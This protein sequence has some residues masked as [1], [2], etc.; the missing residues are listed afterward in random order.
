MYMLSFCSSCHLSPLLRNQIKNASTTS[1][2][3]QFKSI[4]LERVGAGAG[5][6]GWTPRRGWRRRLER[7]SDM[8]LYRKWWRSIPSKSRN[9]W[10][11][12]QDRAAA[13]TGK[14]LPWVPP[15]SHCVLPL[16]SSS[17]M[18][19]RSYQ[20]PDFSFRLGRLESLFIYPF[21]ILQRS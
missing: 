17:R 8:I 20:A 11:T 9:S 12:P 4:G 19:S 3:L 16:S 5:A 2:S 15:S 1:S 7:I 6:D 21:P 14:S 13:S 18:F 10:K